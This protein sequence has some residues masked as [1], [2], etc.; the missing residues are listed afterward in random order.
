M[1][2]KSFQVVN[3]VALVPEGRRVFVNLTVRENLAL[4]AYTRRNKEEISADIEEV[5]ALF[6]D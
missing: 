2:L 6:H 3:R 4:G 1:G 5:Y